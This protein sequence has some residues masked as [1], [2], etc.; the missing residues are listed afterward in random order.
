MYDDMLTDDKDER[1]TA[2]VNALSFHRHVI[3]LYES[4]PKICRKALLF[5]DVAKT[6]IS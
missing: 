1:V 6:C 4:R 5:A 2:S 3:D